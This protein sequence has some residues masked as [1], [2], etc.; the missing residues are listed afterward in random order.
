MALLIDSPGV[1]T[2][3]NS[4]DVTFTLTETVPPNEIAIYGIDGPVMAGVNLNTRLIRFLHGE[5]EQTITITYDENFFFDGDLDLEFTATWDFTSGLGG[6][7]FPSTLQETFNVTLID[8]ETFENGVAFRNYDLNTIEWYSFGDTFD[9]DEEGNRIYTTN[10]GKIDFRSSEFSQGHLSTDEPARFRFPV[11]FNNGQGDIISI[12][13]TSPLP[14]GSYNSIQYYYSTQ[15][16]RIDSY[17]YTYG[18]QGDPDTGSRTNEV[19][20]YDSFTT[21]SPHQVNIR[22][23]AALIVEVDFANNMFRGYIEGY[24]IQTLATVHYDFTANFHEGNYFAYFNGDANSDTT[25]VISFF[26]TQASFDEG[27]CIQDNPPTHQTHPT[28]V[29]YTHLTLPTTPYV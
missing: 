6:N 17:N 4:I 25:E 28:P 7:F 29:S 2:E 27:R 3:G 10:D 26:D 9:V 24:K 1:L 16:T 13:L 11:T 8:D 12:R 20:L 18:V 21:T 19:R 15:S 23:G 22:C 14:D 5:Q